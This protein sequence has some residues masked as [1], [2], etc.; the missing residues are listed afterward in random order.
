MIKNRIKMVLAL[1]LIGAWMLISCEAGRV[2][3]E[4]TILQAGKIGLMPILYVLVFVVNVQVC[5]GAAEKIYK[6]WGK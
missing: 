5:Y 2:A 6:K 1:L 3:S 4:V